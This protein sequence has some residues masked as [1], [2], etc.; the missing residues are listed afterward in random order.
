MRGERGELEERG[1]GRV[2][3]DLHNLDNPET[4][5]KDMTVGLKI[6]ILKYIFLGLL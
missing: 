3:R 1:F 2:R 4:V 5:K 6:S